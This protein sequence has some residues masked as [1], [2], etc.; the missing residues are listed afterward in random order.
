MADWW[1]KLPEEAEG[2]WPDDYTPDADELATRELPP[3]EQCEAVCRQYEDD[4]G[5][6]LHKYAR[7]DRTPRV[8]KVLRYTMTLGASSASGKD[9]GCLNWQEQPF[10]HTAL[11]WTAS[12]GNWELTRDLLQ[13]GADPDIADADGYT[14]LI[15]AAQEGHDEC[16]RVLLAFGA[17]ASHQMKDGDTALEKAEA[18]DRDDVIDVLRGVRPPS[19]SFGPHIVPSHPP[20]CLVSMTPGD[21]EMPPAHTFAR[22]GLLR[23]ALRIHSGLNY[24]TCLRR[25]QPWGQRGGTLCEAS[26]ARRL[27]VGRIVPPLPAPR[28]R[29]PAVTHRDRRSATVALPACALQQCCLARARACTQHVFRILILPAPGCPLRPRRCRVPQSRAGARGGTHADGATA[30]GYTPPCLVRGVLV[31][32]E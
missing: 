12:N 18:F 7:I 17:D 19:A 2:S 16:V 27:S 25:Y 15:V 8:R 26:I 10:G 14:P 4:W 3:P 31:C 29:S 13:A 24:G 21:A 9:K 6:E 23:R 22:L 11:W 32:G 5:W 28:S 20:A 30:R 1:D